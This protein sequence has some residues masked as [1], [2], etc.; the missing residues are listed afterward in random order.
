MPNP[1][2]EKLVDFPLSEMW[3]LQTDGWHQNRGPKDYKENY[4]KGLEKG[5]DFISQHIGSPLT[6]DLIEKLHLSAYKFEAKEVADNSPDPK[7]NL[8]MLSAY[9]DRETSD[10]EVCFPVAGMEFDAGVSPKGLSEFIDALKSA[11]KEEKRWWVTIRI[12]KINQPYVNTIITPE[13]ENLEQLLGAA[14]TKAGES[15]IAEMKNMAEKKKSPSSSTQVRIIGNPKMTRDDMIRFVGKAIQSYEDEIKSIPK[16]DKEN[17]TK[18]ITAIV[19]LIRTLHQTH[20]FEDGNGRT[21]M[22]LLLKM[23]LIKNNL[24]LMITHSPAHFAGFSTEELV[25]EVQKGI[26]QFQEYKITA[27]KQ[28]LEFLSAKKIIQEPQQIQASLKSKLSTNPLIALAQINDLFIKIDNG[29]IQ[30]Q[31]AHGGALY[32][33]PRLEDEANKI[34]LKMLQSLYVET[35]K[36]FVSNP[37]SDP[38]ERIISE[39]ALRDILNRHPIHDPS[40]YPGIHQDVLKA[41]PEYFSKA[42]PEVKPKSQ[43]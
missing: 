6:P 19:K 1:F 37:P 15:Y 32:P 35:I 34:I 13:Q 17:T 8:E 40:R 43:P 30:I 27:P 23:L 22:H 10:F 18:K 28:Y 29:K 4:Y 31:R 7:G 11:Y 2:E 42:S 3:R 36:E 12:Q 9:R 25:N 26:A 16:E 20:C 39:N 24:D 41:I 21:F 33:S 14:L 38:G 5:F